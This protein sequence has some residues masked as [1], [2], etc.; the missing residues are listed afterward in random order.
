MTLLLANTGWGDDDFSG[1]DEDQGDNSNVGFGGD[2]VVSVPDS[3]E[4]VYVTKEGLRELQDE[5]E[6]LKTARRRE[7]AQRLKEAILL[8]ATLLKRSSVV[9]V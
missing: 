3:D 5:L 2:D 4:V 9:A 7:V 8:P 6:H 1:E